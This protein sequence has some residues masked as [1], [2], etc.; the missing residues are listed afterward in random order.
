MRIKTKRRGRLT[1]VTTIGVPRSAPPAILM[2]HGLPV[3]DLLSFT[4]IVCLLV[5]LQTR[6]NQHHH[7]Q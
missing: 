6:F 4:I 3:L 1:R 2:P 7:Q 5:M